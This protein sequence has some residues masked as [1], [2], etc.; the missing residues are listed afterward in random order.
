MGLGK[1]CTS[2][3]DPSVRLIA[4]GARLVAARR[5]YLLMAGGGK[6]NGLCSC[7]YYELPSVHGM[8]LMHASMSHSLRVPTRNREICEKWTY[9]FRKLH[10][11]ALHEPIGNPNNG[12]S[13]R[14][15]AQFPSHFFFC[16]RDRSYL[17]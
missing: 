17:Q 3:P 16:Y 14:R 5:E 6:S 4:S 9:R 13:I 1:C 7:I 12:N 15:S 11:L 2:N 8:H 10:I